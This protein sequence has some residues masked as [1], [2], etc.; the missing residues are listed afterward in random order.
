[1][2]LAS[3]TTGMKAGWIAALI[4]IALWL[5][6]LAVGQSVSP[7]YPEWAELFFSKRSSEPA[8]S[9]YTADPDGDGLLNM[10]E[11]GLVRRPDHPDFPGSTTVGTWTDPEGGGA[12]L[13]IAFDRRRFAPGW[14]VTVEV[15]DDLVHWRDSR[16][17]VVQAGPPSPGPTSDT[18][19]V[20]FR[21]TATM[22]AAPRQY[23]RVRVRGPAGVEDRVRTW[24]VPETPGGLR[25]NQNW[26]AT[27]STP[28]GD[29]YVAGMDHT[30]NSALF[31]LP[32]DQASLVYVG[33]A[34]SASEAASNWESGETAEKFHTRPTWH[35]GRVYVATLDYSMIDDGYLERRG[36]HWY[37]HDQSSDAFID[38][39]A[40]EPG[41]TAIEHGGLATIA[42]DPQTGNLWGA[43]IPE[44]RLVRYDPIAG[45]TTDFGRPP[46]F[47]SG[48]NYTARFIWIDSRGR[49]YFTGGNPDWGQ[50]EPEP[51]YGH[52][53]YFDPAD[54]FGER[55]DWLLESPTAIETGQWTRDRQHCFVADDF[56]RFYRFDDAGPAWSSIGSLDHDGRWLWV[57]HLSAD[58]HSIYAVNSG[59]AEDGLYEFDI[60]TGTTRRLCS[61]ASLHPDL[62]ERTRHTGYDAWD[63]DGRFFFTSFPWPAD[64]DLLLTGVDPVRLKVALGLLPELVHVGAAPAADPDEGFVVYRS[65]S[66]AAALE[67]LADLTTWDAAGRP[68]GTTQHVLTLRAGA[69]AATRTLAD[70]LAPAGSV[71]AALEI[72]PDGRDYVAGADRRAQLP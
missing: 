38:L 64:S 61:L 12:Y 48:Y 54:G 33:D 63:R 58:G 19:R 6:P 60:A 14:T 49:V 50:P 11:Y 9:G 39:S 15:S 68:L 16:A 42:L 8:L 1:M 34:R 55:T 47:G 25:S 44:A 30:T 5:A 71:S 59:A 18:E 56:G 57:T 24:L 17:D 32:A 66:T 65:G 36:F 21:S 35:D 7:S 69:A 13:A 4:F 26:H 20:V 72:I 43:T 29:I 45:S 27:G 67:I 3:H 70:L 62:A 28:A 46:A 23:L 51:I 37:A 41:G 10:M 31:R 2:V 53:H 40:D 52:L 22:D